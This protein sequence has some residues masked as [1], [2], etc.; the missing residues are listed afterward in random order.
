MTPREAAL[1]AVKQGDIIHGTSP[2]G[3]SLICLVTS[4]TES[5]IHART[6]THQLSFIFDRR[7][8]H[9]EE[10]EH[11]MKGIIDSVARLPADI[12]EAIVR[13]D[14]RYHAGDDGPPRPEE[15]RAL[16]FTDDFYPEH[17]LPP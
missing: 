17:P 12:H 7:T 15:R 9:G 1:F 16:K 13:F 11:S 14:Q 5:E 10:P 4:V 8:G 6:V 3:A 2:K